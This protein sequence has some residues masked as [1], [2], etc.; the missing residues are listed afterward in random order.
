M[1]RLW[2]SA[3]VLTVAVAAPCAGQQPK[4]STKP[5][6]SVVGVLTGHTGK[7]LPNARVFLGK[8]EDDEEMLMAKVHLGGLPM[9]QT[10][11]QGKFKLTGFAPG[12]Y[13]I[14][15]FPSGGPSFAPAEISIKALQAVDQSIL[16]QM[17]N[18]EIGTTMP[19]DERKWGPFMLMKG[20]TFW[21]QGEN[22]KLWNATV[23]RGP[24]GPYLEVRKGAIWRT[25]V[26]DNG[27]IEIDAW[28]F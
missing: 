21:S 13:T 2:F 4:P 12:S 3:I 17:K 27:Q 11:V 8:I 24:T 15:Y 14:L 1:H 10:D 22:M 20:H 28:S 18:V 7:P 16:P 26:A 25:D 19:L 5:A 6:T 23:R 9:G